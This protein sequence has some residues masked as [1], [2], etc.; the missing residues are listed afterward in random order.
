MQGLNHLDL[1]KTLAD[2]H[3]TGDYDH[4]VES[5]ITLDSA[6]RLRQWASKRLISLGERVAPRPTDLQLGVST[7]PPCR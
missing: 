3:L 7:G 1:A 2:E 5:H 4:R 6:D